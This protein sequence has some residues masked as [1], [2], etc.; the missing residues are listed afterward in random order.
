MED[1]FLKDS[2][3]Q[4]YIHIQEEHGKESRRV[5]SFHKTLKKFVNDFPFIHI[6]SNKDRYAEYHLYEI[7]V[8]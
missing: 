8:C 2:V 4:N 7:K 5:V 3:R 6:I 1:I